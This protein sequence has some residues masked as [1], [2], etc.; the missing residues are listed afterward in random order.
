[1]RSIY[2]QKNKA[3][4]KLDELPIHRFAASLGLPGA[5]KIKFLNKK[6]K[7]VRED[8]KEDSNESDGVSSGSETQ[9]NDGEDDSNGPKLVETKVRL[10]H[11]HIV[12]SSRRR[13]NRTKSRPN[14]IG[15]LLART[16]T[17]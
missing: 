12:M 5:P 14:M 9:S 8:I 16:K 15:C 4:F 6:K 1:M 7:D 11:S 10:S 3:I 2:L 13:P 17:F